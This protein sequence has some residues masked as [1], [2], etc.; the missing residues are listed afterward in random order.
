MAGLA[1][2]ELVNE[3]HLSTGADILERLKRCLATSYQCD[4]SKA[5][6]KFA[7]AHGKILEHDKRRSRKVRIYATSKWRL[8]KNA[9]LFT[10]LITTFGAKQGRSRQEAKK[11][12]HAKI[13]GFDV[14]IMILKHTYENTW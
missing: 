3:Q 9:K 7:K 10:E 8:E 13:S 4:G 5:S 14:E 1:G 11:T 12:F 6:V 2:E